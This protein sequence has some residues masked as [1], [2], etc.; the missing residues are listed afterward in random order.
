M[1]KQY[2]EAV[3]AGVR[4]AF[5][6]IVLS[7]PEVTQKQMFGCPGYRAGGTLF[8]VLITGG[9]AL[10]K[11][12]EEQR[13]ALASQE[14]VRPFRAGERMIQKWPVLSLTDSLELEG[15]LPF[16]EQSY[17]NALAEEST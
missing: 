5:E 14:A 12:D 4:Q 3:M 7:W 9:L 11:L 13:A 15:Y 17:R 10:T 16:V 2:D 6:E 1:T 8:A